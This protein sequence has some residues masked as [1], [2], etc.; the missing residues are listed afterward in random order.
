MSTRATVKFFDSEEKCLLSVYV[1]HDGYVGGTCGL[2]LRLNS[3]F[4]R[5]K[6]E[7]D[8][9]SD[10]AL[11]FVKDYKDG[12]M[13]MYA[14]TPQDTQ[15]YNYEM[16]ADDKERLAKIKV[17]YRGTDIFEGNPDEFDDYATWD[18]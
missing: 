10:L 17:I 9:I 16:Y 1:H 11:L 6:M 2:G 15:E 8:G 13:D 4:K 7:A 5:Y 12:P 18:R 14:T 3:L